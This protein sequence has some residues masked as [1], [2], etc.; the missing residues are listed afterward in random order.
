MSQSIGVFDSGVGGFTI[1]QAC[2]K[3]YPHHSFV[4]VA[5]QMHLPYG[6]KSQAELHVIL[7][8]MMMIFRSLSIS[9][10]L[11]ACNTLSSLLDAATRQRHSDLTLISI[12]EP[13]IRCIPNDGSLMVL[14]TQATL[15][16]G[17]YQQALL[18]QDASRLIIT[19]SG[20]QLAKD[21]EDGDD[22]RIRAFL[23][24]HVFIH[25]VDHIVLACTHYPLIG[26]LISAHMQVN[27]IDSIDAMCD[28]VQGLPMCSAPSRIYATAH[29]TAFAHKINR[30]FHESHEVLLWSK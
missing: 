4:L 6:D 5:D 1:Y 14:A 15:Q 19:V 7:D 12:I 3:R 18:A 22:L 26:P 9:T 21:I 13:T 29:A 2:V 24:T 16:A 10:I 8:D 20:G 23:N 11:I 25:D 17:K 27:L 30:L 28:M